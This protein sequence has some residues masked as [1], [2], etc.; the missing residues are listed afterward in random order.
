MTNV[1][2]NC[3]L[4]SFRRREAL[5]PVSRLSVLLQFQKEEREENSVLGCR[6]I[7]IPSYYQ[8]VVPGGLVLRDP[9]PFPPSYRPGHFGLRCACL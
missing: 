2:V 5:L 9:A 7:P 1:L 4:A 6:G 8:F 3:C